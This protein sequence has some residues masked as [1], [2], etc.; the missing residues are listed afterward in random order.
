MNN[1]VK[2]HYD[3]HLAE[4]YSWMTG[5]F[6]QKV[7]E[8]KDFFINNDIVPKFSSIAVDLG[9]GHGIQSTALTELGFV[10][11]AVDFSKK[12]LD[13]LKQN[14]GSNVKTVN[15]DITQYDY[16]F[17]NDPELVICM[18]D[19]LTHLAGIND[20]KKVIQNV[21]ANLITGGKFILSY[22]DMSSDLK[23]TSRFIPVK[24]DDNRILTCFL[25]YFVGYVNVNDILHIKTDG[26]WVMKV[27]SY[28]KLRLSK[29]TLYEI[30]SGCNLNISL[31][32]DIAGMHY[33]ISQK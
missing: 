5:D 24:S 30:L 3:E 16:V 13:E 29:E 18:G 19:T 15:A 31:R 22:R 27:S 6:K 4:F 21:S 25:E 7:N 26:K 28:P 12:L 23:G 2:T 1:P 17:S 33:V 11:T 14:P 20:V 10:V 9:S 8:I 32:T